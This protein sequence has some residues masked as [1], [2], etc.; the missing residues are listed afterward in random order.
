MNQR[1]TKQLNTVPHLARVLVMASGIACA[2]CAAPATASAQRADSTVL[3]P[4]VVTAT[5]IPT[6]ASSLTQPVTVLLGDDLRARGV[7]TVAEALRSVPGATIA[8]GGSFG[9]VTSL[10]LRGGESRYTKVLIDGVPVN[11]VG[12]A[13]Y[14]QNLT[15]DNV[16]R[17]EV[18][19][20]PGSA[21][22]GADALTGVIQIFT[23]SGSG[24]GTLDATARAGSYGTR[25]G[26]ASLSGGA[27]SAAY[28]VGADWHQT[29][30][31]IRFNNQY[32]TGTLSGSLKLAAGA[33]SIV[34]LT[35]RYSSSVYHF[36]TDF[37]GVPND[38]NS[39]T[40]QHR[41]VLGVDASHAL[42]S[43]VTLR[44]LAGD[45]E[46]HDLSEDTRAQKGGEFVKTSAPAIG[47]R[48]RVEARVEAV[49]GPRAAITLGSDYE[50][51]AERAKVISYNYTISPDGV[52]GT[53]IPGAD[54]RRITRGYYAAAQGVPT[55]RLSY[56]AS[57]RY[58]NHSDYKD[59]TTYHAGAAVQLWNGARVRGSY[60]TG[61][62]APAFFQTQGS[63]YNR[64]NSALQP[65]QVSTL[66]VGLEQL[67][68]SGKLRASVA[69]FDQRFNQ[70]IQY[71]PG[72]NGGPPDYA[73]LTPAYYDNLTQA[74]A[75]GYQA[76]AQLA[77]ARAWSA[78]LNYTQLL[79]RVYAVPPGFGG[80]LRPGDALLRRPSHSGSALVS[81]AAPVG[82]F[83]SANATYVGKRPDMD[84]AL[85]PSPTITLPAYVKVDLAGSVDVL[86]TPSRTLALTARVDNALDR[87]Y[88]DVLHFPAPGRTVLIGGRLTARR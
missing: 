87:K 41:L 67:L 85:F 68:L 50:V 76:S 17:I 77:L 54:D 38:T 46:V 71:V 9:A 35:S 63:A 51:E 8:Q 15:L 59:V 48:R 53:T 3:A 29:D 2:F 56:D 39:Y 28:S 10:F 82:W 44:L 66:D 70:L 75:R 78:S 37:T 31:V 18:V 57:V 13:F 6:A 14:F 58:D 20:G 86:R 65:E 12:G 60:G 33:R 16:D 32:A 43:A 26:S 24:R 19:E 42:T 80:S 21:L 47:F 64:P 55:R 45:N 61:F 79:A 74:R 25:E 1:S 73:E 52:T 7:V 36:P 34:R 84:F 22:Y 4:V 27:P 69:A 88:E 81:Y 62:N 5:R 72:L 49:S 40:S 83:A 11:A 30:G 23:R